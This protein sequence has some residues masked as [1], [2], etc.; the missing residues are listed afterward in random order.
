MKMYES[1][2]GLNEAAAEDRQA[3]LREKLGLKA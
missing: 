1:G 3:W 2:H